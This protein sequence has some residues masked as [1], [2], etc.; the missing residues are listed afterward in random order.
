VRA[1]TAAELLDLWE[2]GAGSTPVARSLALLELASPRPDAE[3]LGALPVGVRDARLLDL[4]ELLFGPDLAGISSCDGCGEVLEFSCAVDDLRARPPREEPVEVAVSRSGYDVLARLPTSGDLAALA[5]AYDPG[6]ARTLLLER[7][8]VEARHD[9]RAVPAS[10]LPEEVVRALDDRLAELD[11]QADCR[12]E[13]TCPDC[14]ARRSVVLDVGAFLWAEL[15]AWARRTV[16]D[17]HT[18][19]S[20][21][22]WTESEILALGAR[23]RLYLELA[24]G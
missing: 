23:R 24:A 12:V 2:A 9:D 4:R 1:P 8:V 18:L 14:G 21:Y 17:V 15:D 11:P 22:G 6:S 10:E 20:A 7:C 13:L 5:A 19:A 16:H 3:E